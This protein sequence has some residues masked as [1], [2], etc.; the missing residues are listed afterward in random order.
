MVDSVVAFQLDKLTTLLLEEVNAVKGVKDEIENVRDE[1]DRMTAFLIAADAID[2]SDPE[3]R[4]WVKQVQDVAYDAEI[5][6]DKFVLHAL[7]NQSRGWKSNA[8]CCCK[9]FSLM[10]NLKFRR[11]IASEIRGIKARIQSIAEGRLRYQYK[12]N[13]PQQGLSPILAKN[14]KGYDQRGDAHLLEEV[15]LVGIKGRKQELIECI[16]RDILDWKLFQ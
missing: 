5:V 11:G 12:L 16:L 15:E 14:N 7:Q 8:A 2:A 1:F 13:M 10:G 3:I 6:L 9:L 4:V